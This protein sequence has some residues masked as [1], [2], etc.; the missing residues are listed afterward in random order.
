MSISTP[1]ALICLTP[2]SAWPTLP[3]AVTR[4][5]CVGPAKRPAWL[6][7][8]QLL[9][10]H[11]IPKDSAAGRRQFEAQVEQCR[12]AD[13]KGQWEPIRRGWYLGD[14]AFRKELLGQ[15]KGKR[16]ENH[17]GPQA[18]ETD[19]EAA[20][21]LVRTELK[22]LG[23]AAQDLQSRRKGDLKKARVARRLRRETTMTLSWIAQRLNMG[24]AGSLANRLR[25][26]ERKET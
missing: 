9:G 20:E 16:G 26:L 21:F 11:R 6:R 13:E 7:A 19:L 23:W 12:R 14:R 10:E 22:K 24:T 3:G 18:R 25:S 4:S 15:M 17:Y 2:S 8:D 5:I 1:S